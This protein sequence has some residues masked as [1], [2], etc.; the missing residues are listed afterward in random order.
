MKRSDTPTSPGCD[1]GYSRLRRT[2]ATTHCVSHTQEC[3]AASEEATVTQGASRA[4][5]L[6]GSGFEEA[7]RTCDLDVALRVQQ[8]VLRLQITVDDVLISIKQEKETRKPSV[9]L[10]L[11]HDSEQRVESSQW[12]PD[13]T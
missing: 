7:S 1:S 6:V 2:R 11:V 13:D 3:R 9:P 5:C 8:Q 4:A 10:L 12:T